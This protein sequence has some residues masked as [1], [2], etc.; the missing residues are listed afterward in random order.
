MQQEREVTA[1]IL[2]V[3]QDGERVVIGVPRM[4]ADR[5]AGGA[6]GADLGA[7]HH[8]CTSRGDLS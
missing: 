8:A 6:G 5:E 2:L 3:F 4:D 1:L 7:E